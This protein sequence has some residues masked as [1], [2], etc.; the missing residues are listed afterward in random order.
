VSISVDRNLGAWR[1]EARV[2]NE[3]DKR[4]RQKEHKGR[5][6]EIESISVK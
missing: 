2:E 6:K 1:Y 3:R 4:R 5:R